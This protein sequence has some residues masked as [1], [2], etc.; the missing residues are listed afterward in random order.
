MF[1]KEMNNRHHHAIAGEVIGFV[2]VFRQ[3]VFLGKP[4]RRAVSRLEIRRER[5]LSPSTT[6]ISWRLD[7][8]AGVRR[9]PA[10]SSKRTSAR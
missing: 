1:G 4:M 7:P 9:H 10:M 3:F 2:V 5:T 6:T 8:P